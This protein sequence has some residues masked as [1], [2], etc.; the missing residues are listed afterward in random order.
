[1]TS[2]VAAST[3]CAALFPEL[4]RRLLDDPLCGVHVIR[5]LATVEDRG[6]RD[7]DPPIICGQVIRTGVERGQLAG[8]GG[9]QGGLDGRELFDD[10]K[11]SSSSGM[12]SASVEAA[13]SRTAR[14]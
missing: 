14:L 12:S 9:R 10:Q 11:G 2:L 4:Q 5:S 1:M 3:R 8:A 13:A 7:R 6:R